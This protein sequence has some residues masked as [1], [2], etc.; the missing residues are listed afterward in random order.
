MIIDG[1]FGNVKNYSEI[2]LYGNS[3]KLQFGKKST[4]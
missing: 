2:C 3:R 1:V 4:S